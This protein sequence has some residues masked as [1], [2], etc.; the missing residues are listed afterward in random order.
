MVRMDL[1]AKSNW[2]VVP[3]D[4]AIENLEA[5]AVHAL[6]DTL[7]VSTFRYGMYKTLDGMTWEKLSTAGCGDTPE[8]QG[9]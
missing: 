4:P 8:H 9:S 6:D 5:M 2:E 3:V 7:Y 1:Q